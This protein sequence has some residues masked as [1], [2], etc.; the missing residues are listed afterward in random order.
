MA[1]NLPRISKLIDQFGNPIPSDQIARLREDQA[2]ATLAGV[3]P[4]IS[5]F[6][7]DGM[8]PHKLAA[9]HRQAAE[10]DSLAYME[11]AEDIEERDL[12]YL[13]VMSTR[14]RQV[15]QLPI[16]VEAVSED[17]EHEK[18]AELVRRWIK[19]GVLENAL[20]DILDAIGKGFSVTEIDWEVGPD[21]ILPRRLTWRAQRWFEVSRADG[22]TVMMRD[23]SEAALAQVTVPSG[24][25]NLQSGLY[26]GQ[27]GLVPLA[28]HKFIVHK[29][30]AK[31]G[32]LLRAGVARVASWA[33][34]YK[35][36][37][38]R[39]WAVFVQN[40]GMPIRVGKYGPSS[41]PAD[42][43]V[44]WSA[45]A[46]IAGD[47]A[48]IIPESMEIEFQKM[49]GA[50]ASSKLYEDRCN[51]LDHQVSKLVL[52]QTTTTDAIS[53]G[54]AVAQE[55][56]LVQE[57]IERADAR[58]LSVSISEQLVALIISFN[59]PAYV[60]S[61]G[62]DYPR[63]LIGRPDE[64]ALKD[65]VNAIQWLGPQGLT[66]TAKQLRE[67]LGLDEPTEG[68]D[69]V[70]G[71]PPPAAV[72]EVSPPAIGHNKDAPFD[73]KQQAPEPGTS[74]G[75]KQQPPDEATARQALELRTAPPAVVDP[76]LLEGLTRRLAL[77]AQG[78]LVG[79]TDQ[80]RTAIDAASDMQDLWDRLEALQLDPA[81]FQA[82][83]QRG[84]AVGF[85]TGQAALL[86]ELKGS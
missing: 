62:R 63:V 75:T 18:H 44:L 45:V 78:A 46:N 85:L 20:F 54:H 58:A 39:D 41:S 53:G 33:W 83:M 56:R 77:D 52:G 23:L 79:L 67:R 80:V 73:A 6:P 65:I 14:K 66:V 71:A 26:P 36:F 24:M 70:G 35:A 3:R 37:T 28:G 32:I 9:I 38:Q 59:F 81:A 27:I 49:E 31:S 47:C 11:L 74:P 57:D 51:W 69:V 68:D 82:A 1:D 8:T 2:T 30:R 72:P 61:G 84:I 10:G 13:G 43:D 29:H 60:T 15:A 21:G 7:A 25:V 55:H 34:M 50:G 76:E 4:V 5:G 42:R 48:A 86:D 17:P 40:Y 12:H 19:R 22:E 16:Q 64:T